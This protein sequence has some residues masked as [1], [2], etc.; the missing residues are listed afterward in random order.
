MEMTKMLWSYV[1]AWALQNCHSVKCPQSIKNVTIFKMTICDAALLRY[2]P[3]PQT[4]ALKAY[5][6]AS[7]VCSQSANHRHGLISEY[8]L[9]IR[10]KL[11]CPPQSL[12]VKSRRLMM[13]AALNLL[14][15]S[16]D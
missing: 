14:P 12:S 1:E 11:L 16:A 6:F 10:K 9:G 2:D 15:V 3:T 5:N 13:L 8:A 7:S 4:P